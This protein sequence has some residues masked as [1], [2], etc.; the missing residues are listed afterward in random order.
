VL[1]RAAGRDNGT[2]NRFAEAASAIRRHGY[3]RT[4]KRKSHDSLPATSGG[5]SE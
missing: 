1:C 5:P 3:D 4:F 2:P